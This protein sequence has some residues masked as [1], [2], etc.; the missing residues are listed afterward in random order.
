MVDVTDIVKAKHGTGN[1][2]IAK[3]TKRVVAN[4]GEDVVCL[5]PREYAIYQKEAELASADEHP[6]Y[7]WL[8]QLFGNHCDAVNIIRGLREAGFRIE[9]IGPRDAP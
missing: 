8:K 2:V 6:A 3:R 7:P 5:S 9:K 4:Y 1:W